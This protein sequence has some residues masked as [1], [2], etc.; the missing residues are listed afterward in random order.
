GSGCLQPYLY[1]LTVGRSCNAELKVNPAG[2]CRVGGLYLRVRVGH[3]DERDLGRVASGNKHIAGDQYLRFLRQV[4]GRGLC[5]AVGGR[6]WLCLATGH[7]N[8]K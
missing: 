6:R 1:L 4:Y 7:Q 3:V 8:G 5:E 2:Y